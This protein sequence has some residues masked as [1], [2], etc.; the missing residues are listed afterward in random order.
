MLMSFQTHKTFVYLRNT[1]E[2][3]IDEIRELLKIDTEEKKL[4]NTI[5]LSSLR[6]KSILVAS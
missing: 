1:N 3:I 6:T 4:L 2:D 5:I